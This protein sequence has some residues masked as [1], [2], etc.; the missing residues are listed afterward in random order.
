M[1]FRLSRLSLLQAQTDASAT[2]V[3]VEVMMC[4]VMHG[5]YARRLPY[6]ASTLFVQL[7]RSGHIMHVSARGFYEATGRTTLRRRRNLPGVAVARKRALS[8]V[9]VPAFFPSRG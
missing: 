2:A 3:I 9:G 1:L 7:S 8:P 6:T 4:F 5:K